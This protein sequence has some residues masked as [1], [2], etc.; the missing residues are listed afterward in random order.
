M[1]EAE[2]YATAIGDG[3]RALAISIAV[4]HR[5]VHGRAIEDESIALT[6]LWPREPSWRELPFVAFVASLGER[7]FVMLLKAGV[8]W[9]GS[10]AEH[11]DFAP[12]T[13][14]AFPGGLV[15]ESEWMLLVRDRPLVTSYR[16]AS[17]SYVLPADRE[18]PRALDPRRELVAPTSVPASARIDLGCDGSVVHPLAD[19]DVLL[20]Q[21]AFVFGRL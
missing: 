4:R 5:H 9:I 16:A 21:S 7:S 15:G 20:A 13:G 18:L 14:V 3:N 8:N 12:P 11:G 2:R 17:A 19:G 6:P 10:S 1:T